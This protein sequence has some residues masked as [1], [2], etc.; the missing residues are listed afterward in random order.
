MQV[1]EQQRGGPCQF[2]MSG[3]QQAQLILHEGQWQPWPLVAS[4]PTNAPR[5]LS[6]I[7]P[8]CDR[9]RFNAEAVPKLNAA[10]ARA[11]GE[12]A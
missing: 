1:Q 12:A 4:R 6:G 11:T 2:C 10:I 9:E 8:V 5:L 3:E 7:C